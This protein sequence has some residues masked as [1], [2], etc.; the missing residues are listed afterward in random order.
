MADHDSVT[1]H[2]FEVKVTG[3][4]GSQVQARVHLKNSIPVGGV[5]LDVVFDTESGRVVSVSPWQNLGCFV[6]EALAKAAST[7]ASS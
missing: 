4:A 6:T 5:T 3:R 1:P 2:N 7:E